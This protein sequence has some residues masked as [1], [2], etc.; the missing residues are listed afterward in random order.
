[1]F[2]P[3]IYLT[4]KLSGLKSAYYSSSMLFDSEEDSTAQEENKLEMRRR[5]FKAKFLS[6]SQYWH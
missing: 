4:F 2:V 6:N 3:N 5:K 1:M